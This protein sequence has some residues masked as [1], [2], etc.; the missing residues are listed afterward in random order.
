MVAVRCRGLIG[1]RERM[2]GATMAVDMVWDD[3][4]ERTSEDGVRVARTRM[5]MRIVTTNWGRK[6]LQLKLERLTYS[7]AGGVRRI[8]APRIFQGE[9]GLAGKVEVVS[10]GKPRKVMSFAVPG[11]IVL[12]DGVRFFAFV[13]LDDGEYI[14]RVPEGETTSWDI[15]G[16]FIRVPLPPRQFAFTIEG[17]APASAKPRVEPAAHDPDDPYR[18]SLW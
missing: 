8:E 9:S 7:Q 17:S 18:P 1:C 6:E 5:G 3:W 4:I 10:P 15:G 14:A 16:E 2:E 11:R 13:G 12:D